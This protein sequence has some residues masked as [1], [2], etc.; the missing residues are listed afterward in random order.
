MDDGDRLNLT[1]CHELCHV[2]AWLIDH[3]S[4]PP[5]GPV[6][7]RWAARAAA[8]FP[9]VEVT[10]C[11]HY[12]INYKYTYECAT[13][14][15]RQTF[16]RHSDSIDVETQRCGVCSGT[17]RRVLPLRADGTPAT[18]RAAAGFSLFVQERF[19]A[20]KAAMPAGTP[21]GEARGAGSPALRCFAALPPRPLCGVM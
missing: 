18:P 21:H 9:G 17:L 16:G 5:H 14:W 20:A 15:C 1:L 10:T 13:D 7:K 6:F 19:A 12:N 11:H 3:V 8:A 4:K 2:A